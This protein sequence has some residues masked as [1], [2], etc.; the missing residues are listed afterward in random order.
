[1]FAQWEELFHGY[2]SFYGNHHDDSVA[3]RVWGWL[4]DPSHQSEGLVAEAD[5]GIVGLADL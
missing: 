5:S 1:M 2:R 3:E 4:L